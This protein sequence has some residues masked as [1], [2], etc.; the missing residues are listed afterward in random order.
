MPGAPW[1]YAVGSDRWPGISKL[2][3]EAGEVIQVAGKLLATGGAVDHWHGTNLRDRLIDEMGD[4]LAAVEFVA[5]VNKVEADVMA[6]AADKLHI[7]RQWHRDEQERHWA[8]LA[9]R[10]LVEGQ[11]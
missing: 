1:D 11:G 9:A 10:D 3:E 7:F 5:H 6:R 2:I 4:L 8:R